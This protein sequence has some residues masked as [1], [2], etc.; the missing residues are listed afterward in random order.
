MTCVFCKIARGEA[1]SRTVY[2]TDDVVAFLDANPLATGHALV[3]PKEHHELLTEMPE[4]LAESVMEGLY[5][6]TAAAEAAVDA[7]G[8]TV[9]FNN[10][11]AAGQEVGHVHGHVIPRWSDDGGGPIHAIAGHPPD[12][13]DDELDDV[14]A[15]IAERL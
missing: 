7:E 10:G 12:L 14:A 13:S 2:E 4:P 15:R 9:A 5:R 11:R 1:P 3:I 8:T 6:V